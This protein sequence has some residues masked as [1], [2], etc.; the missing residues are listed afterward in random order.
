MISSLRPG[1]LTSV[2]SLK[3]GRVGPRADLDTAVKTEVPAFPQDIEPRFTAR[4][5]NSLIT[6]LTNAVRL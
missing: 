6:I 5:A 3:E 2:T 1:S 4:P